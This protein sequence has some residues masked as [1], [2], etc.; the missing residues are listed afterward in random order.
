M[1]FVVNDTLIV[2]DEVKYLRGGTLYYLETGISTVEPTPKATQMWTNVGWFGQNV[3]QNKTRTHCMHLLRIGTIWTDPWCDT[4]KLNYHDIC[5]CLFRH[6]LY[7]RWK[8][9]LIWGPYVH[10]IG[11]DVRPA[12]AVWCSCEWYISVIPA[13]LNQGW[14]PPRFSRGSTPNL[15]WPSVGHVLV[16]TPRVPAS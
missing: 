3:A 14:P 6:I 1:L 15:W 5:S 4:V 13:G 10:L 9:Q 7:W 2:Y 16:I 12:L 11:T 8:W